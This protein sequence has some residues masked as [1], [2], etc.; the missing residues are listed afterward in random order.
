MTCL[1]VDT[2][3]FAAQMDDL[4]KVL[5]CTPNSTA[6]EIKQ[7]YRGLALIHHPD[8][9]PGEDS[10][11]HHNTFVMISQAYMILSDPALRK[12]YDSRRNEMKLLQELPIHDTVHFGDLEPNDEEY[13]YD[14]RCGDYFLLTKLDVLLNFQYASCPSCSLCIKIIYPP[15]IGRATTDDLH[16]LAIKAGDSTVST[17]SETEYS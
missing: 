4:Y 15:E 1:V 12:E 5:Q 17:A 14:C 8:S 7:K 2:S 16:Q 6:D 11:P 9:H 10:Q 3:S 13:E